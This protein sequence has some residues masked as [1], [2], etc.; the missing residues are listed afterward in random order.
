AVLDESGGVG[1]LASL[2]DYAAN[3]AH[4]ASYAAQLRDAWHRR[5]LLEL[6]SNIQEA[7]YED[8]ARAP[9]LIAKIEAELTTIT[10]VTTSDAAVPYG[11]LVEATMDAIEDR[12]QHP[13]R[14]VGIS[15]GLRLLDQLT[16][17][18][19]ATDLVIIAARPSMGK[20]ALALSMLR[21]A[22]DAGHPSLIFSMEMSREQLVNRLV[23]MVARVN[24]SDAMRGSL[25]AQEWA[26]WVRAGARTQDF[27]IYIDDT[28]AL[29]LAQLRT[30]ARRAVRDWGVRLIV[31]DYLQLMASTSNPHN[32]EQQIAEISRGLKALAK[33]LRIPV[34]ALAQLN[35]SVESR[36]DK[37]PLMSDLRESG[38]IE[39]DADL[40][41]F[42][43]REWVYKRREPGNEHLQNRAELL[44][45][46][47]RNGPTGTVN[48]A[49]VERYTSFENLEVDR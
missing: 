29:D 5:K 2:T 45:E 49:F 47:H 21:A 12:R 35:R 13:D 15:S 23:S 22:A 48:V 38:S 42:I 16:G 37:R 34:I 32:R 31:V 4:M 17:G 6:A 44:L 46:K 43:Y 26:I 7:V 20:T 40:I 19:Q 33:E 18:W 11:I 1:Y 39:Q 25:T 14:Y 9:D 30:R 28:P 8:A 27:P 3:V 41:L 24:A 36:G 10:A